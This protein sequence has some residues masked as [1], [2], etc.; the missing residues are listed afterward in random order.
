MLIKRCEKV[1][2][3]K[4][5]AHDSV[6]ISF[7]DAPAVLIASLWHKSLSW[8]REKKAMELTNW[9]VLAVAK[10]K[11]WIGY[12]L[13]WEATNPWEPFQQPPVLLWLNIA[14]LFCFNLLKYKHANLLTPSL[15]FLCALLRIS[16]HYLITTPLRKNVTA[17]NG[18]VVLCSGRKVTRSHE[19][20]VS[21][22]RGGKGTLLAS[23]HLEKFLWSSVRVCSPQYICTK[24]K[25]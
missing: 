21:R 19:P 25:A 12:F 10:T 17:Q 7:M 4:G 13:W 14:C 18:G 11:R 23:F 6:F 2:I 1:V 20:K 16:N 5:R 15:L 8:K 3:K 22:D 24:Q 9:C